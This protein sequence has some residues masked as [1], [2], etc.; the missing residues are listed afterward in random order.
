MSFSPLSLSTVEQALRNSP[1]IDIV[2]TV[3]PRSVLGAL[4]DGMGGASQ[5]VL[6]AR[7]TVQKAS[8]LHQ[9]GQ[10]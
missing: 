4:A 10:G 6:V 8:A 7:M 3:G 9:Q 5:G 2:D 1:D